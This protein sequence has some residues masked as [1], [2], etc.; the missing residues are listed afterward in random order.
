MKS[1]IPNEMPGDVVYKFV[2]EREGD[3]FKSTPSTQ[4]FKFDFSTNDPRIFLV[5]NFLFCQV[6]FV[7][8]EE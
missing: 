1:T 2:F 8:G 3:N 4:N 5:S 6:N 7:D